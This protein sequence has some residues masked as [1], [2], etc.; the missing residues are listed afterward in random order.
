MRHSLGISSRKRGVALNIRARVSGIV[1][2]TFVAGC[3]G[4]GGAVTM[5]GPTS[6]T[7]T[8]APTPPALQQVSGVVTISQPLI[9][10][11]SSSARSPAFVSS[12]TLHAAVFIDGATGAAGTSACAGPGTTG[13]TGSTVCS[14]P[15][16]ATE[17]VPASHFF[18]VE[19]DS[20][21]SGTPANTVTAEGRVQYALVGGSGNILSPALALNG[22]VA[23]V[24]YGVT[25]CTAN[26]C[27]G[28]LQL[29]T[30]A[31]ALIAYTGTSTFP[32][33][34]NSTSTGTVYDNGNVTFVSSNTGTGGGHVTGTAQTSGA[35]VF[36]TYAT[37]TLTVS[38]VDTTG[39][40][41]YQVTC[42]ATGT[43][44]FGITAALVGSRSLDVTAAELAAL[45][46]AVVYP[47]GITV[48][49]TAPSFSCKNGA[50]GDATG[51][52]PV[53]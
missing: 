45:S 25:S 37:N 3:G 7:S 18:A 27:L 12:A 15:W 22:T 24:T 19:I 52:L 21:A 28:N 1:I 36:S 8:P 10:T 5:P 2:A 26:A 31:G 43:G 32:T 51:I 30:Q 50:I 47:A 4:G 39:I 53:N 23:T 33:T 46:P 41:T 49:A 11:S 17:A 34:G 6:S 48:L 42:N 13:G 14:I 40:Y 29:S 44:A 38:G 9:D 16:T 20:G 35:N